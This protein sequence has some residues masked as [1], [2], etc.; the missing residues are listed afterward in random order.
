MKAVAAISAIRIENLRF[1][2]AQ[3][4][5]LEIAR[6]RIA[7]G[8]HTLISGDS[9]CGKSTLMNLVG[10][11]LTGF[12][13]K[14]EVSGTELANLTA[15]ARDRFRAAHLGVIFQQFNLIPYLSVTEN[16]ELAPRL[17]KKP[18]DRA[19]IQAMMQ[20]LQIAELAAMPAAK[21]SHGQ[22]QRVAA[23]RA[24]AAGAEIVLAD[25]PTSALDDRNARLFLDLLFK[26]AEVNQ[27]TIVV[28]S[29]DLRYRKRFDQ[30]IDLADLNRATKIGP[31]KKPV[32]RKI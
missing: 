4:P 18:V 15:A 2:Y 7:R 8:S 19:R 27:T 21:L 30:F 17:A 32:G 25:E 28:V 13:G 31:G 16:I 24:L 6:L 10:G 23:A 20:H 1:A 26:E 29:H 12:A 14:I 3:K 22:Q 9:G 5:V 11:V